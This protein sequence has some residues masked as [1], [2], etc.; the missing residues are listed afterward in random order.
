M[1][2]LLSLRSSEANRLGSGQRAE[3]ATGP[4]AT[5]EGVLSP[6]ISHFASGQL[7]F[8]YMS[9]YIQVYVY[10]SFSLV[11]VNIFEIGH[12]ICIG[13]YFMLTAHIYVSWGC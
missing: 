4:A 7:A 5:S 3:A 2:I 12:I 1:K 9:T 13:I 6:Q 10:A 8:K 11:P